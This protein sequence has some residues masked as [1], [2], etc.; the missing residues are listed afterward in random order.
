MK[1]KR[2]HLER[3][4]L[5]PLSIW[6]ARTRLHRAF[7]TKTCLHPLASP[8]TCSGPIVRAHTV[9]RA[10]DLS[11]I[12][13]DGHVYQVSGEI[14]DLQ[15]N[16]GRL[17]PKL[18]GI[19]EASTFLGFCSQHDSATFAPLEA[20]A[21]VPTDEQAL[22]LVYRA[23]CKEVYLKERQIES[24]DIAMEAD[25]GRPLPDQMRIQAQVL[26]MRTGVLAAIRDLAT[27]KRMYEQDLLSSDF[28]QIRYV[29]IHL[30][31]A[32]D[33]MC[34]AVAQPHFTFDGRS[35]QDLGDVTRQLEYMGFSLAATDTGGVAVFAW[36]AD[37]DAASSRLVDS[38]LALPTAEMPH[39]LVRYATSEFEN[40]YMRPQWWEALPAPAKTALINRLA[41]NV[42]PHRQV[43]PTYLLDDGCRTVEWVVT[44]IVDKRS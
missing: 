3:E 9:R 40:T 16:G 39:A 20:F 8:T 21:L 13:R 41:H 37:S 19:N 32:P 24:L 35:I 17:L 30:D 18:V 6:D 38:L 44:R 23:L 14:A 27:Q 29:A 4:A 34:S 22:L 11:V 12:A 42:G 31:R 28:G 25:R 26:L 33:L 7:K 2:C 36:R 10:A 1:Y 5:Q 43:E 15:R